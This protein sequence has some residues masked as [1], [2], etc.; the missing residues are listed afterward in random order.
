M[1]ARGPLPNES[2]PSMGGGG[3]RRGGACCCM[4]LNSAMVAI[5]PGY[6]AAPCTLLSLRASLSTPL[7]HSCAQEGAC[8]CLYLCSKGRRRP[9]TTVRTATQARRIASTHPPTH[10]TH[11]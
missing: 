3:P 8:S 11:L 2:Y 7:H 10:P 5:Y 9:V 4:A 6:S 1:R